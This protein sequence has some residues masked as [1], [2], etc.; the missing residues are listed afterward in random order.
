MK[1][2]TLAGIFAGAYSA[3]L[4]S[5]YLLDPQRGKRRRAELRDKWVHTKSEAGKFSARFGRD[6]VNR[7]EGAMAEAEQLLHRES[8]TDYVLEQ[9]VH[10]A[11]GRILSHPGAVEVSAK[12]GSVF[13]SGWILA[14]EAEEV[15]KAVAS[16]EG[17]KDFTSYL[18]TADNPKHI[19]A[20]QGGERR[21]HIPELFQERWSPSFRV[22]AGCTGLGLAAFGKARSGS[23]K[24]PFAGAGLLLLT[25]SLLNRPFA[26]VAGAGP[27]AGIRVQKT[28]FVKATPAELYQF[29][30]N[31]ENYPKALP[32]VK[33]VTRLEDSLYQWQLSGTAGLTVKWT[34]KMV[35]SIPDK[36]IEWKS[37]PGAIVENHGIIHFDA[38]NGEQTRI[39]IQMSYR[40][41]AGLV[42]HAFAALL[43][44]DP[45]TILDQDF[46][47]LKALFNQG[48]T[49]VHGHSVMKSDVASAAS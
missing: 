2:Q 17:V 15:D 18:N 7:T 9:R 35:R 40:P 24:N 42:G 3:G 48:I 34:G 22:L 14:D 41:P 39:Q 21:R 44:I 43:G 12:D 10:T 13:L 29:W 26:A 23:F 32:H 27:S 28:L 37:S 11:L 20:L 47:R 1:K 31:P 19:P 25:R 49:V 46:V 16:I 4:L 33:E 8:P 36:L 5:M 30:N 38:V 45:K 6:L